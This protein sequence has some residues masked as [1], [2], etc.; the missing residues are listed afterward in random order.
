MKVRIGID[1]GGTFT[2]AVAIDETSYE[3]IGKVKV[4][5]THSASEG[6]AA[7]I[8]HALKK[9]LD[10]YNIDVNDVT[11]LAHGT[12][13]ATNAFL[14][15]D[16]SKVGIFALGSGLEGKKAKID[17][18][19]EDIELAKGRFLTTTHQYLDVSEFNDENIGKAIKNLVDDGAEVLVASESYSVDNPEREQLIM[20]AAKKYNIPATATHEVSKLYGLRTRT[21]TGVLNASILPKMMQTVDMTEDSVKKTGIQSQ[22]MI[23]RCDGGVMSVDEVRSRPILTMLSGPAAGVAGAL[24]YEKVSNGIFL[25]VGG[26]STDISVIKNGRVMIEYAQIG[27]HKT[28]VNSLDVRTVGIAGGSMIKVVKNKIN[29]VGPRSAHIANLPYAVYTDPESIKNAKVVYVQPKPGDSNDYVALENENGDRFAITL[30]CVANYLGYVNEDNYAFGNKESATIAVEKL[31]EELGQDAKEIAIEI[32][33]TAAKKNISVIEKMMEDYDLEK[34]GLLM[35]GGGGG[36]AAVVPYL[37]EKMEIKHTINKNAEVISTIGV[38]LA[39][40]REMVERSMS[41]PTEED[42]LKI[43]KEAEEAVVKSGAEPSTVEV[44]VEVD[45]KENVVRAIATGATDLRTK[46]IGKVLSVEQL[47]EIVAETYQTRP[48]EIVEEEGT[49]DLH[50]IR[51]TREEKKLW[52][53]IKKKK[54]TIHVVD[55]EGVI[56]LRRNDA[57][58]QPLTVGTIKNKLLSILEDVIGYGDGGIQVPDVYILQG[59]RIIDCSGVI[60]LDQIMALINVELEGL[61]SNTK[62]VVIIVKRSA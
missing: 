21:R 45:A 31:A 35:L 15:G 13:Q 41:D 48:D 53:L 58:V 59:K 40:V 55:N 50:V 4:P 32:S 7:G 57:I 22:L 6:V 38:A 28:Y 56:K 62:I 10:E 52:G 5:T 26:T 49:D 30:A 61:D 20:E 27:G 19:I 54:N 60:D 16:V 36:A 14:E 12:T 46:E 9:L 1:V 29:D 23:M 33:E 44:H 51:T 43:R 39:M 34:D 17:S 8:I 25:E 24:M 37:A 18:N 2:D 11:F 42:I 3:L 47:K